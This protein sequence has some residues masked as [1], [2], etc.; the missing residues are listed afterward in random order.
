MPASDR[1]TDQRAG[2]PTKAGVRHLDQ[3]LEIVEGHGDD[4]GDRGRNE[5]YLRNGRAA[6]RDE[7]SLAIVEKLEPGP[8]AFGK[9]PEG[10]DVWAFVEP[11][12]GVRLS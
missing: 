8:R 3:E 1:A 6:E 12:S 5:S 11:N 7:G 4:D 2:P 10:E 9:D